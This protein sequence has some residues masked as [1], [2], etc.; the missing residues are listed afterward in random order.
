MVAT[1]IYAGAWP[2]ALFLP[3][4]GEGEPRAGISL[5]TMT[6]SLYVLVVV[7]AVV[8]MLNSRLDTRSRGQ[9]RRGRVGT[10][11]DSRVGDPAAPAVIR[12]GPEPAPTR[13]EP[14]CGLIARGEADCTLPGAVR[15]HRAV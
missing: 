5:I 3:R 11:G 7:I 8:Q 1:A 4:D 10:A 2:V 15:G 12:L 6:T 14:T 9:L 13:L